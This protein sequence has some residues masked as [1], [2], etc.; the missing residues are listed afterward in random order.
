MVVYDARGTFIK[1][2]QMRNLT[3]ALF[4]DPHKQLWLATVPT[5]LC[6]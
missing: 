6:P 5:T 2:I 3:C 1:T 4:V